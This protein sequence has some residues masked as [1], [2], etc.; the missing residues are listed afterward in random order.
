MSQLILE[1]DD[2]HSLK[3]IQEFAD[4]LCIHCRHIWQA[5]KPESLKQTELDEAIRFV[6]H[7]TQEN[8]SFGDALAWQ[9]NVRQER[10]LD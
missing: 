8:S 1:T 3:L 7:F 10:A 2:E 5:A 9:K 4:K 6:E